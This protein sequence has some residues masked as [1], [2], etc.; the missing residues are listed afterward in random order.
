MWACGLGVLA[1]LCVVVVGVLAFSRHDDPYV[2]K[3]LTVTDAH[4]CVTRAKVNQCYP[5]SDIGGLP[6]SLTIGQCLV[7]QDRHPNTDYIK[8]VRCPS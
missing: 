4:V 1:V 3:V 7:L 2:V 6:S 8:T 5:R